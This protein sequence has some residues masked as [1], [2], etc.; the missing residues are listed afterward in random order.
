MVFSAGVGRAL[1]RDPTGNLSFSAKMEIVPVRL[2][3]LTSTY[4]ED[5]RRHRRRR[6]VASS[7][8]KSTPSKLR[9]PTI[10]TSRATP[11]VIGSGANARGSEI[12]SHRDNVGAL[13]NNVA[14]RHGTPC[15]SLRDFHPGL[16]VR[17]R[18]R[19]CD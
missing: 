14:V 11:N 6:R 12:A 4:R 19:A 13:A 15:D 1:G 3:S 2:A 16:T 5:A 9:S 7:A 8:S 18:V 10:R 17:P